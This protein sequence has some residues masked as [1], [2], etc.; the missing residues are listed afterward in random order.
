MQ[1]E[2]GQCGVVA[3]PGRVGNCVRKGEMSSECKNALLVFSLRMIVSTWLLL[4]CFSR[5]IC[6]LT[7]KGVAEQVSCTS[8]HSTSC[9]AQVGMVKFLK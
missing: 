2:R 7:T 6:W 4:S 1:L 8:L 9:N 3:A 5:S